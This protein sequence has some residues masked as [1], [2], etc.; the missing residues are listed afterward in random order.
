MHKHMHAELDYKYTYM[1]VMELKIVGTT[2]TETIYSFK[3]HVI[4]YPVD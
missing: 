4:S 3:L 2:F 1:Y